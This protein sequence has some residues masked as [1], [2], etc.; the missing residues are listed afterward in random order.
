MIFC[1]IVNKAKKEV[2]SAHTKVDLSRELVYFICNGESWKCIFCNP[3][4]LAVHHITPSSI[5]DDS[6]A[7]SV[8]F[9]MKVVL[10]L[11]TQRK[12]GKMKEISGMCVSCIFAINTQAKLLLVG[13]R[14]FSLENNFVGLSLFFFWLDWLAGRKEKCNDVVI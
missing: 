9:Q 5:H 12:D 14:F 4:Q 2:Q 6:Q 11:A 3:F 7:C 1:V 8:F 10:F 13:F